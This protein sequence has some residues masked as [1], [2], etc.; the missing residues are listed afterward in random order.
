MQP[1]QPRRCEPPRGPCSKPALLPLLH[2]CRKALRLGKFLQNVAD[3]RKAAAAGLQQQGPLLLLL[4]L[5]AAGG[6]G[7]YYFLEQFVWCVLCLLAH[8]RSW[9]PRLCACQP[10]AGYALHI[11]AYTDAQNPFGAR[12]Q[13]ALSFDPLLFHSAHAY[14]TLPA[15]AYI[16]TN[17]HSTTG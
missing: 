15:C 11:G 3:L 1:Q 12:Q 7:V 17:K 14:T 10:P 9:H 16:Q 8:M 2:A 5:V 4:E 6:E 13:A